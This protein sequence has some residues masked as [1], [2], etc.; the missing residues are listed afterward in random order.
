MT[1]RSRADFFVLRAPLLSLETLSDWVRGTGAIDACREDDERLGQALVA[2]R[3]LLRRRLDDL[4]SDGQVAQALALASPDLAAGVDGWRTHPDA[5]ASRSVERSL[6][7]YL[8]RLASRPDLFGLSGAYVTGRFASDCVLEL[9]PR[10]ELE[11]RTRIDSRLLREVVRRAA[12]SAAAESSD[13]V[14]RRNPSVYRVGGRLRVAALKPGS[15]AYRLVEIRPTA[16]IELALE[17]ATD[18]ASIASLT[19]ALQTGGSPADH[20]PDLVRRLIVS[21]LLVPVAD[22]TVT[23]PDPTAQADKALASLP[24]GEP[25][26]ESIRRAVAIV[27][28][29]S[30][31]SRSLI[32]SAAD[33]LAQTG[34]EVSRRHCVQ[35][36]A[37]RPGAARLPKRVLAEMRRSIDVLARITPPE[38]GPLRFFREAFE[39]RFGTR[40]VPLLE[41]LD[42][43]FGIRIGA[44]GVDA[45]SPEPPTPGATPGRRLALLA[46][47]ERGR[48]AGGRVE[49]TDADLAALSGGRSALLPA[50]FALL[51]S[52][53]GR[54]VDAVVTGDFQL[55]E[56]SLTGPSGVRLLGR[57][58]RGDEQLETHVREHLASEQALEPDAILAELSTAAETEVG[59]NIAQRPVLRDW[60]IEYGGGSGA[61]AGRR[62]DPSD[63][64]VSV[65]DDEVVLRSLSLARRVI[66]YSTTALNPMWVSLPAA[67]FLLSIAGQHSPALFSWSWDPFGDA[68]ALPRVT[69]GRTVLALRRW[70]ATAADFADVAAGTDA[71]GFR[72]LQEWR[73]R[74]D[75]PRVVGFDH[76]KSRLTVDFGNAL[77]VEAFLDSTKG[78]E[79]LSFVE[80][81]TA[82][83]SLVQGPDGHYAHE[84][85]VP[86]VLERKDTP[87]RPR[88]RAPKPVM[89]SRRRFAPGTEWLYAKLYGPVA[90]A[91]RVLVDHVGP[92]AQELRQARLIDRWFFIR[93]SDP[94]RHLR[95][96]FRG[97]PRELSELL[98][99]FHEATAPALDQ[100]LV[101]RISLDTYEREIERYGGLAGAELM[102]QVAE[103]DSDAVI[104]TLRHPLDAMQRRH[105]AVASLAALYADA[106]LPLERRHACSVCLRTNW[107]PPRASLGAVLGVAERSERGQVEA[108]V[109]AL[110]RGEPDDES[111]RRVRALRERSHALVPILGRLRSLD[112][113]GVLEQPFEDVICSLAHMSVNRLLKR[114]GNRD[115][116]RVHDALARLYAG[117]MARE[118]A[119]A[120]S[121]VEL[122]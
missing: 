44:S 52:V 53:A 6:V 77:S 95:V 66:P 71:A 112:D 32:D 100:G 11:F 102:E 41:A 47:L 20:A 69:R 39:R 18:G 17:T 89:E 5:K 8:T 33:A 58:C 117:Q 29:G 59:L 93:Y 26:A 28:N 64:V 109:A 96:R 106:D 85:V 111:E 120:G 94:A 121:P 63:L 110:N 7:R 55:L 1:T 12:T 60:E 46:L 30:T 27:A 16:A 107:T 42:P 81:P 14:V 99:A 38:P 113:E 67:R 15:T 87:A 68:A 91:D 48:S 10:A 21:Q 114:G 74:R 79:I 73:L 72:R 51:T 62:I 37:R 103:A 78:L 98:A 65:E 23:G 54:D 56:P 116:L 13:L 122:A 45:E 3:A 49:L 9:R 31:I 34:V 88:R 76:P 24:G 36:D 50:S 2:D 118:R 101:Y 115:E 22:V 80:T 84:L 57:L 119:M 35:V 82:E 83:R 40:S 70:N 108:V 43:D 97:R 75:M 104:E 86:F 92:L 4:L 90:A 61:P 105:V 19:A 25:Y